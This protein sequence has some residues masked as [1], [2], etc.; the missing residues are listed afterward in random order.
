M[1]AYNDDD[2]NDDNK[3]NI[4]YDNIYIFLFLCHHVIYTS[5]CFKFNSY[6]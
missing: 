4:N 1:K 5:F 3:N 2:N 6:D